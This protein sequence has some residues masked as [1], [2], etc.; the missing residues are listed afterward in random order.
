VMEASAE[1]FGLVF[2]GTSGRGVYMGQPR[3]NAAESAPPAAA[4]ST[5]PQ[6]R[7]ALRQQ[8]VE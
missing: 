6:A 7:P 2:L 3:T 5:P 1:T 4:R 8:V